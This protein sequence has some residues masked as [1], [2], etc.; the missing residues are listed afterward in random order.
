MTTDI[1]VDTKKG[2]SQFHSKLSVLLN[3]L[4]YDD[5]LDEVAEKKVELLKILIPL[6][7]RLVDLD[8]IDCDILYDNT[9]D[10]IEKYDKYKKRQMDTANTDNLVKNRVQEDLIRL[11]SINCH[12]HITISYI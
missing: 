4:I 2:I 7:D 6:Y 10:I 1:I 3:K 5:K 12:N 11:D 9:R 8:N